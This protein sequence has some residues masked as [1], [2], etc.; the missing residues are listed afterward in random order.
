[1]DDK[2]LKAKKQFLRTYIENCNEQEIDKLFN[3]CTGNNGYR[4]V[5]YPIYPSY[6]FYQT[7]TWTTTDAT[8]KEFPKSVGE[9][10]SETNLRGI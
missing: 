5:E 1:M 2:I 8:G 6:P 7:F 9:D 10:G 4:I 3:E